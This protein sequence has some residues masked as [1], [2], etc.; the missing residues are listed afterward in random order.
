[1]PCIRSPGEH[2]R[3]EHWS[4]ALNGGKV[5]AKAMLGQ[6]ATLDTIP[7]FYT[8]QFDVSMEYSGFPT[9]AAGASGHP[10]L[11]GGQGV[12]RA[13]GSGTGRVVAG[14]S[15]NWPRAAQAGAQKAIKA[16]ISA[17]AEVPAETAGRRNRSGSTQLIPERRLTG[18]GGRGLDGLDSCP[19]MPA[20]RARA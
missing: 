2:H 5:A 13:S 11:A 19:A 14:M 6:D 20:W 15:V 10:R 12:H 3:S 1:M 18:D 7:Y 9:L 8:D 17:R 16:L 4:N